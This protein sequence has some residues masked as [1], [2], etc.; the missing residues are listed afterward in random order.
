MIATSTLHIE[1]NKTTRSRINDQDVNHVPFGK[2]FTD[3]MFVAEYENGKWTKCS[4]E[5]YGSISMSYATC[6]LHYG[7]TIFEGMKAYRTENNDTLL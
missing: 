5:P 4:I 6:A 3:H 1:V 7:Q 2:V